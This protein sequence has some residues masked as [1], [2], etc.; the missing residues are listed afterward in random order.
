MRHE[1]R[2][3][4]PRN[5]L[6]KKPLVSDPGMHYG[7][8]VTHVPWCMSRSLTLGRRGKHSRHSRR[9]R[10]AQFYISGQR[11]MGILYDIY[12]ILKVGN[13]I[14][15][16]HGTSAHQKQCRMKKMYT[17]IAFTFILPFVTFS[18]AT[19]SPATRTTKPYN[20]SCYI[21]HTY[22]L[23]GA[24][25]TNFDNSTLFRGNEPGSIM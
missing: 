5:R 1:C 2:E 7:T 19:Y 22:I 8:C 25:M 4:F 21:Q 12:S 9:M 24:V 16:E 18:L 20:P 17:S 3:R 14:I 15:D 13:Y 11:P 10:N 23:L 6:Q